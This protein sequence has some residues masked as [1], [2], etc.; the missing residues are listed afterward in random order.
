MNQKE[1]A[2]SRYNAF[3]RKSNI[4]YLIINKYILLLKG[5]KKP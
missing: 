2:C 1:L 5:K 4:P 3:Q